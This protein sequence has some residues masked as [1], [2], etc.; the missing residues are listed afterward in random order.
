MF[1]G[2]Q[3]SVHDGDEL[4]DRLRILLLHV[5]MEGF[6]SDRLLVADES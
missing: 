5:F 2:C 4:F 1:G 6:R 3:P